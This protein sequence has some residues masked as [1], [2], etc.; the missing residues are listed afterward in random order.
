MREAARRDR[1]AWAPRLEARSDERV[2]P[3]AEETAHRRGRWVAGACPPPLLERRRAAVLLRPGSQTRNDGCDRPADRGRP[4]ATHCVWPTA[5]A[6]LAWPPR[7]EARSRDRRVPRSEHGSHRRH[8]WMRFAGEAPLGNGR[9][10][11]VTPM[12]ELE[13]VDDRLARPAESVAGTGLHRFDRAGATR[14]AP[15][16]HSKLSTA[17]AQRR[18][19]SIAQT[20]SD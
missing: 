5:T 16:A 12:P 19:S 9:R 4:G 11:Q 1:H 15:F 13:G 18:P 2:V 6:C 20:I 10:A 17:V 7:T 14:A 3:G 8:R